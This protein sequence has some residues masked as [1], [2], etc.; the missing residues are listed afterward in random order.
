[1]SDLSNSPDHLAVNVPECNEV[2]SQI[3]GW[4]LDGLSL[5]PFHELGCLPPHVGDNQLGSGDHS[6]G[7][8]VHNYSLVSMDLSI[9]IPYFCNL[10]IALHPEEPIRDVAGTC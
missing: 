4:P 3:L 1:M 2:P 9:I 6:L 8:L 5:P 7:V 10:Q